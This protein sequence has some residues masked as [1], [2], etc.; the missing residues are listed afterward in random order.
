MFYANLEQSCLM[1]LLVWKTTTQALESGNRSVIRKSEKIMKKTF[2]LISLATASLFSCVKPDLEQTIEDPKEYNA[3]LTASVPETKVAIADD[4]VK[5]SWNNGDEISVLTSNGVYKT[6]VYN[7]ESGASEA[8]FKGILDE[9]ET[10]GGYAIYP[11]NSQHSVNE[12]IPSINL[13]SEYQWNASEVMGPMVAV[14]SEGE[15]LFTHAGGLFAFD[16]KNVPAGAKGFKFSTA[17]N[18][19]V[20]V[21]PYVDGVVTA[22]TSNEG[23]SVTMWFNALEQ[24][25]DMKFY[26][27]VPVG[28][29]E[30]FTVSYIESDNSEKIIRSS[31]SKNIIAAATVKLFTVKV[32][33][34]S[35]YV[36]AGGSVEADGLSWTTSTT[37]DNALGMAEDGDVIHV[38]AGTYKPQVALKYAG[39]QLDGFKSFLIDK[40]ITIIGGYPEVPSEGAV[41]D[42]STNKT[43]LDGDSKAYHTLVVAAP[44][45]AGKTVVLKGLVV[46]GGNAANSNAVVTLN[47]NTLNG[48][49][50][51][52]IAFLG[53]NAELSDVTVSNNSAGG[54]AG[55]FTAA[56]KVK[57]TNC[58]IAENTV[59]GG[60]AGG[61]Q[62]SSGSDIVMDGCTITKNTAV[63]AGGLYLYAAAEKTCSA[64][65][66]NTLIS[67][68]TATT[69]HGAMWVRD[70]SGSHLLSASFEGCTFSENSAKQ[71]A[72]AQCINADVIFDSCSFVK[73][74]G[75]ANGSIMTLYENCDILMDKCAFKENNVFN[76]AIYLYT[77]AKATKPNLTISNSSFSGNVSTGDN[78][79]VWAR[80]DNGNITF[81][82]ANSTFSGNKAAR[83]SAI[84]LYKVTSANLISN[85][86][87]G[88][89]LTGST[90]TGAVDNNASTVNVSSN[91]II[92]GN[93][94]NKDANGTFTHKYSIIGSTCY[95]ASGA[96]ATVDP[97]WNVAEMLG[98]LNE[99]GVC[100]LL[101]SSNPAL[102]NGMPVAELKALAN[103][104]LSADVLGKDQ[105]GNE[106]AGNVIGAY[107][108][109]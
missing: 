67:L 64:V 34:D 9:G 102:T 27:P 70:D 31:A 104:Y 82:C 32:K 13:P 22:G 62:F 23:S 72:V 44:V 39:D 37:L 30:D 54:A 78:G 71:S 49:Q 88:N 76:G 93:T 4:N 56:S 16:A 90:K 96:A 3:T 17:N 43:V 12:G 47:S 25:R 75:T 106:R 36:T 109:K 50:G 95:N 21:F 60:N 57:M 68:N 80:G 15:A 10:I 26:I 42:A 105:L 59:T 107:V 14:V 83:R 74:T 28:T 24:N 101:G 85:T 108:V 52:G 97:A 7:G 58:T 86:I 91:N 103:D 45:V 33:N 38:A 87:A 29:Y 89:V 100:P 41:A 51:G 20:G 53:T 1:N 73:N 11:A 94:D 99:Y 77:N 63:N 2:I 65:I 6:F 40:N 48:G 69:N 92:S 81:N 55:I 79:V 46:K 8:E 19:L 66:K 5:L 98:Q 18:E 84:F 35:Y 61:A